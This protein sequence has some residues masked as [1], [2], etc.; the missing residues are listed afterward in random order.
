M[1]VYVTK[2]YVV[3]KDICYSC[4]LCENEQ[5]AI[6]W[7]KDHPGYEAVSR[8]EVEIVKGD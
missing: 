5:E 4:M 7:V 6:D 8:K 3:K 1:V 2:W